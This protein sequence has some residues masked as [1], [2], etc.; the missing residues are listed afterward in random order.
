[1]LSVGAWEGIVGTLV[2]P[3]LAGT[4]TAA[5]LSSLSPAGTA[6]ARSLAQAVGM[7]LPKEG[8]GVLDA[9]ATRISGVHRSPFVVLPHGD[10]E[11]DSCERLVIDSCEDSYITV[12]RA[13]STVLLS[14]LRKCT[15]I[16][17][18]SATTATIEACQQ[19][20]IVVAAGAISVANCADCIISMVTPSQPLFMG[21]C[22]G[23]TLAPYAARYNGLSAQLRGMPWGGASFNEQWGSPLC[24]SLTE[25]DVALIATKAEP[26][27]FSIMELD[28]T[29][30]VEEDARLLPTQYAHQ[31][32]RR[33]AA[34]LHM[35]EEVE[36]GD[37][38][39]VQQQDLQSAIQTAFLVSSPARVPLTASTRV[40]LR[41]C[42][43]CS[44]FWPLVYHLNLS[45]LYMPC[46]IGW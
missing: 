15:V 12:L 27:D 7:A 14:N 11:E 20:H 25:T 1:M 10:S 30:S 33:A 2:R 3:A 32:Q 44:R 38:P 45:V 18:P 41:Q 36:N 16:L 35:R 4:S 6:S 23:N 29:A 43:P 17:G 31:V 24:L 40:C 28:G 8:D 26:V 34:A 37:L 22:R 5:V 42:I 19:C 13:S 9:A 39:F 21:D 46:R